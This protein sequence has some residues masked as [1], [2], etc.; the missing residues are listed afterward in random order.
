MPKPG[1]NNNDENSGVYGVAVALT[2]VFSL[3]AIYF[4]W[5]ELH[6]D[7]LVF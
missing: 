5:K 4:I 7:Y 6:T 2:L 1:S 3:V